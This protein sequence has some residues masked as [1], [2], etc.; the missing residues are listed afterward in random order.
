MLPGH[1]S[2]RSTAARL[3]QGVACGLVIAIG[4]SAAGPPAHAKGALKVGIFL[5]SDG[6]RCFA[7][8][9]VT[10]IRYFTAQYADRLNDG[11]GIDG[12]KVT[13]SYFDDF[14][15]AHTAVANVKAALEDA[16]MLAMIG[17]PS[18]TRG[19]AIFSKLGPQI[20][21]R[22]IPFITE[23]SLDRLFHDSPNVFTM[24]SS[25]RNEL[26][27]VGKVVVDGGYQRPVFV[28]LSDDL[29][30]IAL[31]EGLQ[32]T[33]WGP[34]LAANIKAPVVDYK[35]D[36]YSAQSIATEIAKQNPDII[37]LAIH[38]GPSTTLLEKLAAAGVSAPVFV[39]LG[40]IQNI[41][42]VLGPKGYAGPMAQIAR[43]GVPDVYNERLRQRIWRAPQDT[44]VFKDVRNGDAPGWKDGTCDDRGEASARVLFDAGNRRAVGRGTQYRD[45]LQLIAEAVRG[46]PK[47][48][49]IAELRQVI[50]EE[51]RNFVEGRRVLKGLWQDWAFTRERTSADDTLIVEKAPGEEAVVLAPVQYRRINGALQ[52]SP[53]VYTSIDLISL[54]RIDGN[55]R[56]FDAQFYLSMKSSD[57]RIGID[58]IEFTNAYR[59]QAG[60]G[61]L[62]ITREINDGRANSNFPAGV[63]LYKV[64]GKF[65]FEPDLGDYPFDVQRLSVS[66]QPANAAEP[67]LIQP[68]PLAEREKEVAVDGWQLLERYVGSDQD[69][70]PTFGASLSEQRIVPFYKFNATWIVKRLAVDYYL[71]VVV[72]LAFI[73]LVT[74][75]SV[76]LPHRRF[77]SIMAIEVTAL[78]SAI[79]L[80]LALPKVDSDQATFSDKLFMLTY[81]AVTLMIG[82]S[83]L[84]DNMRKKK[85]VVYAVSFLQWVVFPVAT[86]A[87]VLY[88][89][90]RRGG[91]A[92]PL[93]HGLATLWAALSS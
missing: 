14:E 23:I 60:E 63:K 70:V 32:A 81:A 9:L 61:R 68:A 53:T 83:I 57:D 2:F 12:R 30:S 54:S 50:G 48:A 21:D 45:M 62:I 59:S 5:S 24:S 13:L 27:V 7:P 42:N 72:P 65:D 16:D 80:Y 17:V 31:G 39:L 91:A 75:F 20:R 86:A 77:E 33:P 22:A 67:F 26:E 43:E 74:Y 40:R 19:E 6:N 79:A 15:D 36:T 87:C 85:E 34:P 38:S 69:I 84:K 78:L 55:D 76:F 46:A 82:L 64:S 25:V 89:L 10:A 93:A 18:S 49:Q 56:S 66:F 28:G 58:S 8:G 71:R 47:E 73:L 41:V 90:P 11:G 88:L 52:R 35:L 3:A 1:R 37:L 44:W 92:D 29:Y 4:A 51:L